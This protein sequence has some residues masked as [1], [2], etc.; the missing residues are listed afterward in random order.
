MVAQQLASSSAK[1]DEVFFFLFVQM[2]LNYSVIPKNKRNLEIAERQ[3][4]LVKAVRKLL[5]AFD[6]RS[7][8]FAR[9]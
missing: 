1:S 3:Q 2:Y 7:A 5:R 4:A 6:A 9:Y 8:Q